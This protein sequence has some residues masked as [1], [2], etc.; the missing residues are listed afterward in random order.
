MTRAPTPARLRAERVASQG[1]GRSAAVLGGQAVAVGRVLDR[2]L[3]LQGQDLGLDDRLL[4]RARDLV[5]GA[6]SGG[7]AMTRGE[8]FAVL[9]A[10]GVP[11]SA[12]RGAHL[13]LHFAQESLIVWGP[14]APVGQALVLF[15]EWAPAAGP[16]PERDEALGRALLGY[17]RGRAPATLADFA[18]WTKLPLADARRALEVLR[19]SGG[20]FPGGSGEEVER[21]GGDS[22]RDVDALLRLPGTATGTG[23]DLAR[24]PVRVASAHLLPGFDELLLGP[25]DLRAVTAAAERYGHFA[26]SAVSVAGG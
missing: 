14:S 19:S 3:A 22:D 23:A 25:A 5:V 6:L 12:Q 8:L 16:V 20:A 18:G 2:M 9:E 15:D 26:D 24:G 17:L 1:I 4:D 11:T 7:V 13:L 21:I 10:G